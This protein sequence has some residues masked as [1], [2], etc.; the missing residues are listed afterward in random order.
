MTYPSLH[1]VITAAEDYWSAWQ[2]LLSAAPGL[3]KVIGQHYPTALSWKVEGDVAP[4]EAVIRV[5]ELGDHIFLA[6]V[7]SERSIATVH[8][9]QAIALDTL[10]DIKILQRRPSKPNDTLGPDSLDLLLPHGLPTPE[11]IEKTLAGTEAEVEADHNEVHEWISVSYRGH[12][13]KLADHSIWSICV[14]EAAS[15]LDA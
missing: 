4:L 1:E 15:L 12:E 5:Y 8:K 14:K 3:R 6:P 2:T 9:T 7:N 11:A 10:Q 13:F